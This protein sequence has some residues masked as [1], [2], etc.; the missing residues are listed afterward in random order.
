LTENYKIKYNASDC[1]GLLDG[2]K[3][4]TKNGEIASWMLFGTS[5]TVGTIMLVS[6][7]GIDYKDPRWRPTFGFGLGLTSGS[8]LFLI[9]LFTKLD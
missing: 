7:S 8:V 4:L 6:L 5:L 2:K 1:S 9:P 3:I